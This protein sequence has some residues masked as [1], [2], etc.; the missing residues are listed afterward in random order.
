MKKSIFKLFR[1]FLESQRLDEELQQ[2]RER[3]L[4]TPTESVLRE[5]IAQ[6]DS[7]VEVS[8]TM[9]SGATITVRKT[10]KGTETSS[11]NYKIEGSF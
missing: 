9:N 4:D 6:A 5:M 3:F 1:E 7:G 8:L 11:G 2:A 10:N